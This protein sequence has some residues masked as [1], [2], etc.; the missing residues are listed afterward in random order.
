MNMN[1]AESNAYITYIEQ[2]IVA[3]GPKDPF[4]KLARILYKV[5]E[6][7]LLLP[8]L[9]LIPISSITLG[10]LAVIT[11]GLVLLPLSLVWLP[12]LGFLI[13][14]SWMWIK[15]P[16]SRP[17]LLLPG[18]IIAEIANLYVSLIPD[19]GEK[20]QKLVKLGLCDTWPL[21]YLMM[22]FMKENPFE[23]SD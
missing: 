13:G 10:L 9:I 20:H 5:I 3:T 23:E 2:Q 8:S 6:L 4:T 11:F 12:F 22:E 16:I 21:T 19:M 7:L 15:I 18:V 1:A 14:T 17:I